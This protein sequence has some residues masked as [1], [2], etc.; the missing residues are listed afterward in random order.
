MR[1]AVRDEW[2]RAHHEHPT[3][4]AIGDGTLSLDRFR[5]YMVQDYLFL[6]EYCRVLAMACSRS[7]DLDSMGRWAALLDETLNSEMELHRSFCGDFG[8]SRGALEATQPSPTTSAYTGFLLAAARDGSIEE[9][10]SA[11][12]P[13]QWGYDA[14]GRELAV[15][16]KASPGTL[17]RRW[18][19]GYTDPAY[20]EMTRW[21][22]GFVDAL[23]ENASRELRATMQQ[24][25]SDGVRHEYSFWQAAWEM[26]PLA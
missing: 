13:C 24:R 9:I 22:I 12:L 26:E 21:L 19:D 15:N 20:Q 18:I 6:I 14:I 23:A 17:H 25:F 11:L 16:G 4:S 10:A 5:Y 8:I 7:P 1:L 2:D 3:V